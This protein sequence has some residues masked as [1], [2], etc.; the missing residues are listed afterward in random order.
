M[1]HVMH[2]DTCHLKLPKQIVRYNMVNKS[3]RQHWNNVLL[4][5]LLMA[6]TIAL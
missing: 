2:D 3:C 6:V 1:P 5:V 4:S